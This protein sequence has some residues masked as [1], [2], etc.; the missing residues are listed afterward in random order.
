MGSTKLSDINKEIHLIWEFITK[1]NNWL[2][3]AYI[4]RIFKKVADAESRKQELEKEWILINK[5]LTLE[6]IS[7][8]W[9]QT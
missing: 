6:T 5:I 4:P 1:Q 9:I 2:T 8:L 3:A 7:L